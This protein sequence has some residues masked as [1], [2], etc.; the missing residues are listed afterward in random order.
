V[1]LSTDAWFWCSRGFFLRSSLRSAVKQYDLREAARDK[2][3][4]S[5]REFPD[6]VQKTVRRLLSK[7]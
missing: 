4:E 7:E 1:D 6:P 3:R 5:F 2:A